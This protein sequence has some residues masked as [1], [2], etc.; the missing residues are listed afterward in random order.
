M[1]P[2]SALVTTGFLLYFKTL[3]F[4]WTYLDDNVL[5]INN[6]RFLS[7][8]SN[9]F[10]AFRQ[11]VFHIAHCSAAYYRPILTVSFILDAQIGGGNPF[12]YHLTNVVIHLVASCLV[13]LFLNKLGYKRP[14][15]FFFSLIFTVHPILTQAVAWIPGRND[16]L[17]AVFGLSAFIFFLDFLETRRAGYYIAHLFFLGLAL[18]TKESAVILPVM[19]VLY[20]WTVAGSQAQNDGRKTFRP[21]EQ[22]ALIGGWLAVCGLWFFLRL[23]AL[24]GAAEG[25][26]NLLTMTG[27]DMAKSMAQNAPALIQFIGKIIFP[28]NLSVL[29]LMRDT[30]FGYGIA[31]LALIGAALFFS[32]SSRRGFVVFGAAW[33]ILFLLP[34]FIRPNPSIAADFIEHRAY[35]P[36]VGF[37]IVLLEIDAVKRIEWTPTRCIFTP[38]R[39]KAAG[40]A[41][42]GLFAAITFLH[43]GNFKDR[44]SF[45]E[46]AAQKSPHSPLAHRNLGAMYYLDGL[47]DKAEAEYKTSLELNPSEQMAHNNIGLIYV[48]RGNFQE[49]EEEY[50]KE[51]AVNPLY[52]DAHFNMGLLYYKMGDFK[53]AEYLWK[54]TLQI[55]PDHSG[56]SNALAELRMVEDRGWKLE[57]GSEKPD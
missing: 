10:Q 5:V 23:A 12:I 40:I 28:F 15:A 53:K 18:F 24:A 29:P 43:S 39:C 55:N 4:G 8:L 9:V 20:Y 57:A 6:A 47:P 42:V 52:D 38:R 41:I 14:L 44:L 50:K 56:A 27:I 22:W 35:M 16:S 31:A 2:I 49:A 17:M 30:G 34:S 37:F 51:L 32:K 19:C 13:Y 3:F 25:R 33:F 36:L 21:F 46:N 1:K 11:E 26:A 7:S 54:K 45:W 48:G